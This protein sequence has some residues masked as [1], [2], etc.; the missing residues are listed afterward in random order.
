[1]D[2][3][4]LR[5]ID[6]CS[7]RIQ[8]AS[9]LLDE[10]CRFHFDLP[11]I[12]KELKKFRHKIK[13]LFTIDYQ[14]LLE[15]RDSLADSGFSYTLQSEAERNNLGAII[16]ASCKRVIESL[17]ILEEYAKLPDF[18]QRVTV[19]IEQ[20][21]QRFYEIERV[22]VLRAAK[23]K[24]A[25]KI[26]PINPDQG[27]EE[28]LEQINQ[29]SSFIQLRL[30]NKSKAEILTIVKAIK[31][32]YP[33]L[34]IIM[35]DHLDI[36]LAE[37]LAGVH[38]GQDDLPLAAARELLGDSKLIGISTHD[39]KQAKEAEAAGADYIG[40]GP[41]YATATK[42]TGYDPRG[43][44]LLKEITTKIT[45]PIVAIGGITKDNF[46]KVI[47][48]GANSCAMISELQGDTIHHYQSLLKTLESEQ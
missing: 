30:K 36:A 46:A 20:E 11:N 29:C 24:L 18:C 25:E 28:F 31:K 8:E 22:L 44:E 21:R 38:L 48:A 3:N 37:D 26:Y 15:A 14:Q 7:N 9:R 27:F 42:D 2:K 19:N 43:L 33:K 45:I 1:M 17:R 16:T 35:N 34:R 23:G 39:L 4:I 40:F 47:T 6:V 32:N 41:V 5:H 13:N 12:Q 10:L